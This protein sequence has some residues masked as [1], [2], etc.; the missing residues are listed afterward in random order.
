MGKTR[1]EPV[2][3]CKN[4]NTFDP[5]NKRVCRKHFEKEKRYIIHAPVTNTQPKRLNCDR[6]KFQVNTFSSEN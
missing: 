6:G 3:L 5:K 2:G 4:K 1:D